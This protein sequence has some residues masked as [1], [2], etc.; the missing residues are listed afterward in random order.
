MLGEVYYAR[1]NISPFM[2]FNKSW[3]IKKS[4]WN[5]EYKG[6]FYVFI[7]ANR[8]LIILFLND[9]ITKLLI[10]NLLA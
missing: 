4:K 3:L 1:D 2:V 7:S 8:Y 6:F 9:Y 5:V 10:N